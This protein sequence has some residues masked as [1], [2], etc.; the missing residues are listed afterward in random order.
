METLYSVPESVGSVETLTKP[1][2]DILDEFV[3][4]E[5]YDFPSLTVIPADVG[6]H[7]VVFNRHF[8][9]SRYA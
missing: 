4:V 9:S 2:F 5:V 7:Y 3:I 6:W 1:Q 8:F